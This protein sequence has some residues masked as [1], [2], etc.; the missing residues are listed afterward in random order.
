MAMDDRME[1]IGSAILSQAQQEARELI[2]KANEIRDREISACEEEIVGKMYGTLQ[3]KANNIRLET[4][5]NIA[6]FELEAYRALLGHRA[7]KA[8]SVFENV[9]KKLLDFTSTAEYKADVLARAAAIKDVCDHG[10]STIFVRE[11]DLALAEEIKKQIGGGEIVADPGIKI[12]GFKIN[13]KAARILIDE[14]LDERLEE[15]RP[16]FLQNCK[17]KIM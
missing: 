6:S 15:Q 16:W 4:V 1:L 13:N 9:R 8:S 2:D 11:S 3:T 12:G 7:E 5:K 17:M 10:E 14:T